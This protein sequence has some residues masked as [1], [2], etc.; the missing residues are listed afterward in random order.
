MTTFERNFGKLYYNTWFEDQHMVT[1]VFFH[2][3]KF[4]R[5][6]FFLLQSPDPVAILSLEIL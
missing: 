3:N 4:F 5:N 6:V 2:Q 1:Y